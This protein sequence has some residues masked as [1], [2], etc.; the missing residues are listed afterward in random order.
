[1]STERGRNFCVPPVH[2]T[3]ANHLFSVAPEHQGCHQ[4][5][6]AYCEHNS[7]QNVV[8]FGRWGTFVL[9]SA[10]ILTVDAFPLFLFVAHADHSV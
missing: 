2:V 6:G 9:E 1:M 10:I 8:F 4:Y 3:L 7:V 5:S